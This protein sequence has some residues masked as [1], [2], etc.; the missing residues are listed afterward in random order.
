MS[1]NYS[2]LFGRIKEKFCTQ[3]RFSKAM[4]LSERSLSLKLNNKM[5]WKQN[6]ILRACSLLEI[7]VEEVH[8]YFFNE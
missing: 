4:G 6:E 5:P 1:F 3:G 8:L 7:S 2:K